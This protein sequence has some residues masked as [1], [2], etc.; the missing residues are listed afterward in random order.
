MTPFDFFAQKVCLTASDNEWNI[1]VQEFARVGLS[2]DKFQ[3]LP[4][5]PMPQDAIDALPL[6]HL[7]IVGP[8][9]SFNASTNRILRDFYDT[10]A[11]SLLFLEDDCVFKDLSHL[12]QALSELPADWDI[13]YLGANLL[14]WN[15]GTEPVPEQY[16]DNLFRVKAAWTTHAIGYNRKMVPFIVENQ[17]SWSERMADNWISDQLPNLNAYCVA[18]MVAYQRARFSSI[19][20][21]VDD[22]TPLFE[23]S[24]SKLTKEIYVS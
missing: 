13:V 9:Q 17:P 22:Y 14:M 20:G 23:A 21:R 18:P 2:P 24:D 19:W 10:G 1:A 7:E 3:A 5:V 11:E 4:I 16:S 8:H 12:G 6:G 15:N